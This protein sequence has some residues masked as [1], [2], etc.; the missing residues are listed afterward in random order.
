VVRL[1]QHAG[2]LRRQQQRRFAP[3]GDAVT[4][5][6]RAVIRLICAEL[7]LQGTDDVAR[8]WQFLESMP[9]LYSEM[10]PAAEIRVTAAVVKRHRANFKKARDDLKRLNENAL[11]LLLEEQYAALD[12]TL[13]FVGSIEC[14]SD[15]YEVLNWIDAKVA[16]DLIQISGRSLT[17]DAHNAVAALIH[18]YRTGEHSKVRRACDLVRRGVHP[19]SVMLEPQ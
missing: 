9:H 1:L 5:E 18:E 13:E 16:A 8:V 17:I 14:M 4:A 11:T 7:G 3:R 12:Q 2:T 6:P 19:A 15:R 10:M